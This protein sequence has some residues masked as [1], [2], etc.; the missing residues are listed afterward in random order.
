MREIYFKNR[1]KLKYSHKNK[2]E[3][4]ENR[5]IFMAFSRIAKKRTT[6]IFCVMPTVKS[7]G[8]KRKMLNTSLRFVPSFILRTV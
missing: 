8:I 2:A 4:S 1:L 7:N 3:A 6:L 5:R